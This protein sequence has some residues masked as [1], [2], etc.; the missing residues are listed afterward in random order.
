[1][2]TVNFVSHIG[3]AW[4]AWSG[5][6]FGDD[7]AVFCFGCNLDLMMFIVFCIVFWELLL[8]M[9]DGACSSIKKP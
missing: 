2:T 8:M 5:T 6:Q 4:T 9:L 3:H 7:I 1:M